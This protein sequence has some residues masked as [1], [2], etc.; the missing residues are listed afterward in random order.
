MFIKLWNRIATLFSPDKVLLRPNVDFDESTG[1]LKLTIKGDLDGR[2]VRL[3]R[4]S[5][6]RGHGVYQG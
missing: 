6:T 2:T 5:V 1:D 4:R 3:S